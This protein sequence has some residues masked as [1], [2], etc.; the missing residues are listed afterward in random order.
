GRFGGRFGGRLHAL[1]HR[2]SR[3]TDGAGRLLDRLVDE[4]RYGPAAHRNLASRTGTFIGIGRARGEQ[5]DDESRPEEQ[6]QAVEEL[7]GERGREPPAGCRL[8]VDA[9]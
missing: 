2:L 8:R 3:L 5:D 4:L 7:Q 9:Y 6:E 1:S